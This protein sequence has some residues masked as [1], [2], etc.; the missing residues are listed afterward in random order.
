MD[1]DDEITS[2]LNEEDC[3]DGRNDSDIKY[4]DDE[5]DDDGDDND[6]DDNNRRDGT[7][8]NNNNKSTGNAVN[9][10]MHESSSNSSKLHSPDATASDVKSIDDNDDDDNYCTVDI[11]NN[12]TA[13]PSLVQLTSV[14]AI[15]EHNNAVIRIV[16]D[17]NQ[18][19]NASTPARILQQQNHSTNNATT[20]RKRKV[21]TSDDDDDDDDIDEG[22]KGNHKLP[23]DNTVSTSVDK[24]IS[25]SARTIQPQSDKDFILTWT[26][27][28][29]FCTFHFRTPKHGDIENNFALSSDPNSSLSRD[30]NNFVGVD[31]CQVLHINFTL[32]S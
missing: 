23:N 12:V 24:N 25:N 29:T 6:N 4:S 26:P 17:R 16:K 7:A 27:G 31:A 32:S 19:I 18:L 3:S 21:Y 30:H 15:N 28:K 11:N 10:S 14:S 22:S 20:L 1:D 8:I 2:I 9:N 13:P 5:D